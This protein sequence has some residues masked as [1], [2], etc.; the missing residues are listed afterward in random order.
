MFG[1]QRFTSNVKYAITSFILLLSITANYMTFYSEIHKK[2]MFLVWFILA[3]IV[4]VLSVNSLLN[5]VVIVYWDGKLETITKEMFLK[6]VNNEYIP[7]ILSNSEDLDNFMR[8]YIILSKPELKLVKRK[9]EKLKWERSVNN[10]D[11]Y[12]I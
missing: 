8:K 9:I 12:D 4:I 5:R 6:A 10:I 3:H 2:T 1:F 11:M 7:Y